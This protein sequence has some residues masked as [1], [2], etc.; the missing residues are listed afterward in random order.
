MIGKIKKTPE[1][2]F[3]LLS[4]KFLFDIGQYQPEYAKG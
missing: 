2:V 4:I 1:G 3:G